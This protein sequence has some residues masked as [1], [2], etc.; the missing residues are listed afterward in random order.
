[1]RIA[2]AYIDARVARLLAE[3]LQ[4]EGFPDTAAKV[5]D[6][7]ARK[8]TTELPLVMADH[9]AI[10][11]ALAQNCPSTMGRLRQALLR[12]QNYVRRVAGESP[13]R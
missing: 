1:M 10:R 13:E 12:E 7:I 11:Q 2:G 6:G 9:D 5:A 8:V 4:R 3:I